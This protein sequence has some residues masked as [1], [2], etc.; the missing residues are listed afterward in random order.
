M[1][2]RDGQ[3]V[4]TGWVS[5]T[6][7]DGSGAV[8]LQIVTTFDDGVVG[9][10][11]QWTLNQT[12]RLNGEELTFTGSIN[13]VEPSGNSYTLAGGWTYS[14]TGGPMFDPSSDLEFQNTLGNMLAFD[15]PVVAGGGAP[16]GALL[17]IPANAATMTLNYL[18]DSRRAYTAP[19]HCNGP[20]YQ[21]GS[22]QSCEDV[23]IPCQAKIPD[24]AL[25]IDAMTDVS[26]AFKK[27]MKGRFGCGGSYRRQLRIRCDD[28][29]SCGACGSAGGC[30]LMGRDIWYCSVNSDPCH[31]AMVVFHEAAHSC[32]IGHSLQYYLPGGGCSVPDERACEIG[33]WFE[34]RCNELPG[35]VRSGG[36]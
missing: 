14:A 1:L 32:G 18:R 16:P 8:G 35:T 5:V 31:C 33:F 36:K 7:A 34:T 13:V 3:E 17:S 30:N 9:P 6:T 15:P 19:T 23:N 24:I 22:G 25:L 26:P 12:M 11:P 28:S 2:H 4:R 21:D 27:C 29:S 10:D 20:I